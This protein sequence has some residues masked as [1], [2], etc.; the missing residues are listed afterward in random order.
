MCLDSELE[1]A[2][3]IHNVICQT[4]VGLLHLL[5]YPNLIISINLSI[6]LSLVTY[7]NLIL[8]YRTI[9]LSS[10]IAL[11]IIYI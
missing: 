9:N 7:F 1:K 2:M 8:I 3:L 6:Y 11:V 4:K 5:V 10:F